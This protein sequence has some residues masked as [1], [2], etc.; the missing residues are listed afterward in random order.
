MSENIE[1]DASA[2]LEASAAAAF[3]QAQS[4][5]RADHD[6]FPLKNTWQ[7]AD[8]QIRDGWRKIAAAALSAGMLNAS[9][10]NERDIADALAPYFEEGYSP[11]DGADA[12]LRLL[13]GKRPSAAT[14]GG[15][16]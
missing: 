10:L 11:R 16:E 14:P 1:E 8:E 12:V 9:K 7:N 5:Y 2:I 13:F 15:G 6:H 4:V 3:R